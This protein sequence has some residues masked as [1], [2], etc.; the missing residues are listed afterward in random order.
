MVI[1]SPPKR[2]VTKRCLPIALQL[3]YFQGNQVT[4]PFF[5][6]SNVHNEPFSSLKHFGSLLSTLRIVVDRVN[7]YIILSQ[8]SFANSVHWNGVY[9]N[10]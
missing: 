5:I 6:V 4:L 3:G 10:S 2:K 8:V 1:P 7:L 9:A